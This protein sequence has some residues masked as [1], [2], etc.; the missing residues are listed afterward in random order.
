MDSLDKV[1]R[2]YTVYGR[3][4]EKCAHFGHYEMIVTSSMGEPLFVDTRNNS[5]PTPTTKDFKIA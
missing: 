4:F 3:D 5:Q 1:P 2:S